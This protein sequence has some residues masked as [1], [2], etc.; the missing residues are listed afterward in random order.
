MRTAARA[1]PCGT[2]VE[3]VFSHRI[4]SVSGFEARVERRHVAPFRNSRRWKDADLGLF[5]WVLRWL[6][7]ATRKTSVLMPM[8]LESSS[9]ARRRSE[10]PGLTLGNP[11]QPGAARPNLARPGPTRRGPSIHHAGKPP[12]RTAFRVNLFDSAGRL[13]AFAPRAGLQPCPHPKGRN[14]QP[15]PSKPDRIRKLMRPSSPTACDRRERW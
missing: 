7:I 12:H 15:A 1:L 11:A 5:R 4:A 10:Q 2:Q 13:F 9:Q 8:S 3:S 6:R 14:A